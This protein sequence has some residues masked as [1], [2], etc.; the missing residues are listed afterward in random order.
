MQK[1]LKSFKYKIKSCIMQQVLNKEAWIIRGL[2]LFVGSLKL[3]SFNIEDKKDS[4]MKSA[5]SVSGT[6]SSRSRLYIY[7]LYILCSTCWI[8]C[9]SKYSTSGT[10]ATWSLGKGTARTGSKGYIFFYSCWNDVGV[11]EKVPFFLVPKTLTR[12]HKRLVNYHN[13]I[14]CMVPRFLPK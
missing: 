2:A 11:V 7:I 8:Y 9:T 4:E 12:P 5:Y 14:I 13:C 6:R 10:R 1:M 3:S